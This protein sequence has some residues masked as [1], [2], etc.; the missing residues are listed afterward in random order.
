MGNAIA[1]VFKTERIGVSMSTGKFYQRLLLSLV[2]VSNSPPS[3][4]TTLKIQEEHFKNLDHPLASD[5]GEF[6]TWFSEFLS[7]CVKPEAKLHGEIINKKQLLE[8]IMPL[9][10]WCDSIPESVAPYLLSYTTWVLPNQ[11]DKDRKAQTFTFLKKIIEDE[12]SR[13]TQPDSSSP[14]A[15]RRMLKQLHTT[16]TDN[17]DEIKL[18]FEEMFIQHEAKTPGAPSLEILESY[19]HFF[20]ENQIPSPVSIWRYYELLATPQK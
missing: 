7:A 11:I 8:H 17:M 16:T 6:Q 12:L 10:I 19:F 1:W 9:W 5:S 3:F 13:L 15:Y 18:L 2:F 4:L 14:L 20:D